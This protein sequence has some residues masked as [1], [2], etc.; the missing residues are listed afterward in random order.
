MERKHQ[1]ILVIARAL[2]NR[3]HIPI[4]YYCECILI[5][6]HLIN[7]LLSPLLNNLT[8]FEKL[9]NKPPTYTHIKVFGC[10]CYTSTIA[11]KGQSLPLELL[12]VSF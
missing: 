1:H 7:R 5:A 9:L 10:L 8:P 6:V 2:K 12:F 4:A 3:S 11:P